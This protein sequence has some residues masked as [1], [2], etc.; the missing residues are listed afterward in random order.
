MSTQFFITGANGFIGQHMVEYLVQ[1]G[2]EVH[3]LIRPGSLPSFAISEHVIV[4]YGDLRDKASLMRAMPVGAYVIHFAANPYHKTL[5]HDVNVRGTAHLLDVIKRKKGVLLHISTQATKILQ[6]GVYGS[7]KSKSDELVRAS[8]IPFVIIKPSLVYGSGKKGLFTKI[9]NLASKLPFIPVFGDGKVGLYPIYVHDLCILIEKT[10]TDSSAYGLTFDAGG[11]QRITY[12][13]LYTS[14]AQYLP[15]KPYLVHIHK[16][17]GL[18]MARVMAF[19]PNPPFY[20]DNIL[21]STQDTHCTPLPLLKRYNHTPM[22][23]QDGLRQVFAPSSIRVGIIGLGKMGML[24]ATL[25][26]TMPNVN[27]VALIDTNPKLVTTFKSMGIS[28]TFFPSLKEALRHEKLDAV[29]II[30]PTCTHMALLKEALTNKLH[31]FIEKPVALNNDQIR[32][33]RQ[34][35]P[36]TVVH[37]GY[38]LLYHRPFQE[39]MRIINEKRYGKVISFTA[40]FQHGEVLSPKKGWMF[41][42]KL[43][44]GGVLMNPGPHLFSIIYACFGKPK[45]VTGT[46]KQKYSPEVDD[47]AQFTFTYP[48]FEGCVS[49]SWSVKGK[50]IADYQITCHCE[51]AKIIATSIDI[52]I[53][54]ARKTTRIPFEKL[55]P[56]EPNLFTINPHAYGEA[57]YAENLEFI[58]AIRGIKKHTPNSLQNALHTEDIIQTCYAKGTRA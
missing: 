22:L 3:T 8:G 35:H 43:S 54:N 34:L 13:Q 18:F 56:Q 37:T 23:F 14:I 12:N 24:H 45:H 41:T 44:G 20:E 42:K 10:I 48:A 47:E 58:R 2:H 11:T 27:I 1:R 31:V 19:L 33:I 15:K 16:N 29:Y 52:T 39:L 38:T 49:L 7:T 17:F 4:H 51:H 53:K 55:S 26:H 32:E 21:G 50:H 9:A 30:T 5:S 25:L 28:G 6:R 57:Y 40:T 46:L 36:A